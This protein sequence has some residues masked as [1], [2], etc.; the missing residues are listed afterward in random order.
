MRL[1]GDRGCASREQHRAEQREALSEAGADDDPRGIGAEAAGAGE[2]AGEGFPQLGPASRVAVAQR[3][4]RGRGEAA[5]HR[6]HPGGR[7]ERPTDQET[8]AEVVARPVDAGSRSCSWGSVR[9]TRR[10][11]RVPD[12]CVRSASPPPP[13]ARRPRPPCYGRARDRTAAARGRQARAHRVSRPLPLASRRASLGVRAT[14]GA[15]R[16]PHE[17]RHR[18]WPTFPALDVDLTPGPDAPPA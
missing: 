8:R 3:L 4:R 15:P 5:T 13:A 6:G 12:L 10:A 9:G 2:V 7:R 11:T 14:R 16:R 18:K 1:D 17:G